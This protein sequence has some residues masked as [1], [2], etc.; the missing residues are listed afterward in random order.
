MIW[1]RLAAAFAAVAAA[2]VAWLIVA[3]LVQNVF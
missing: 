2:T 3:A 1:I